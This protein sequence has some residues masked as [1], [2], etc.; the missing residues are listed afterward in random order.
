V[1]HGPHSAVVWGGPVRSVSVR[2]QNPLT[3]LDCSAPLRADRA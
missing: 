3:W 2:S 1:S